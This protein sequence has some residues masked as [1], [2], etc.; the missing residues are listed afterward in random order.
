ME[1]GVCTAAGLKRGD[2]NVFP[3]QAWTSHHTVINFVSCSESAVS[4]KFNSLCLACA[5]LRGTVTR[6]VMYLTAF[7]PCLYSQC[8]GEVQLQPQWLIVEAISCSGV[9]AGLCSTVSQSGKSQTGCHAQSACTHK[10]L[11]LEKRNSPVPILACILDSHLASIKLCGLPA[12]C[13]RK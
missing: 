4:F 1:F 11:G 12:D 10:W 7:L 5:S 8:V 9:C 2:S 13:D 3:A 6:S